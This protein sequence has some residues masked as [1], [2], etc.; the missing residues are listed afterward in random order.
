MA[1]TTMNTLKIL[2]HKLELLEAALDGAE[3][4]ARYA[5]HYGTCAKEDT[6][7]TYNIELINDYITET[8]TEL[9]LAELAESQLHAV[10]AAQLRA[11]GMS[12]GEGMRHTSS[13]DDLHGHP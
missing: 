2:R 12:E 6:L 1:R 11:G 5:K 7:A 13:S 4:F 10:Q 8:K 9:G 3:A